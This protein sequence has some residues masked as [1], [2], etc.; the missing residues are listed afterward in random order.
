[1]TPADGE[2]TT[3][4]TSHSPSARSSSRASSCISPR[5]P[6]VPVAEGSSVAGIGNCIACHH[7]PAFTDFLVHNVGVTQ[8]EY[9]ALHG[10]G[11]SPR[12]RFPTW[13]RAMPTRTP[14]SRRPRCTRPPPESSAAF[15]TS[16]PGA[17]RPR[18]LE[19]LANPDLPPPQTALTSVLCEALSLD[20]PELHAGDAP[21]RSRSRRSRRLASATL[22]TRR[23]TCTPAS[24][25]RSRTC[26]TTTRRSASWRST[27]R[28]GTPILGSL[29][30]PSPSRSKIALAA[31]LRALFED[32]D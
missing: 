4:T 24:S 15:P 3:P 10:S 30:S 8:A 23:P 31:F 21:V 19:R 2:F 22:G 14:S 29:E 18:R 28:C 1:M 20:P 16:R 32:Y 5:A 26:S 9:D 11:A 13:P 17:H 27:A 25:T 12:S 7:A 6:T